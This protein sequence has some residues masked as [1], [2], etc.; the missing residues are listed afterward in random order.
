MNTGS[1][2]INPDRFYRYTGL[3]KNLGT[4]SGK[5]LNLSG[6]AERLSRRTEKIADYFGLSVEIGRFQCYN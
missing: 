6:Y 3:L 2:D 1:F 4:K 5:K